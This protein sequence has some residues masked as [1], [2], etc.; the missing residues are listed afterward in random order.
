M[1]AIVN[2]A[3]IIVDCLEKDRI[4]DYQE[5]VFSHPVM[6]PEYKTAL[7][8]FT[9]LD[10]EK[11]KRIG[12]ML[13]GKDLRNLNRATKLKIIFAAVL[14]PRKMRTLMRAMSY[15]NKYSW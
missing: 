6:A 13:N 15:A 12:K 9:N 10:N 7:K 2:V 11:L 3:D 4:K 5:R 8:H 14:K 1:A